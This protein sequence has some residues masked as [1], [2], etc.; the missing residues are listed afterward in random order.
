MSLWSFFLFGEAYIIRKLSANGKK[1]VCII[2][3]ALL[4][5][6]HNICLSFFVWK[7]SALWVIGLDR[8]FFKQKKGIGCCFFRSPEP[9][10]WAIVIIHWLSSSLSVCPSIHPISLNNISSLITEPILTKFHR[11]V[12]WVILTEAGFWLPW[13]PKER[14][15]TLKNL[16]VRNHWTNF[17]II[18]QK[19]SFDDPSTKIGQTFMI[20]QKKTWPPVGRGFIFPIYVQ[21]TLKIF[22]SETTGPISI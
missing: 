15:K 7:K 3:E 13:Q 12:P 22:L 4:L 2:C 6:I 8:T 11:I 19:C 17:N 10:R 18:W 1:W 21:K 5:N 16:L 14:K 20:S 9:S